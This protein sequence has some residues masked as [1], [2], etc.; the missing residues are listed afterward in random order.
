MRALI[1]GASSGLGRDMARALAAR[2][3]DLILVACREDRLKELASSLSV[4]TTVSVRDLSDADECLRLFE[5]WEDEPLEMLVNNAG[6]GLFGA[7]DEVDL[8]RELSMI[9]VNVRAVHILTKRFAEK[10]EKQGHGRILN[11]ASSAG[12]LPGPLMSTYY[13]T[14]SYVVRYSEALA[15]ELRRRKSPVTI[16]LLC[17]GPV[18]TEFDRVAGVQFSLKGLKSEDVAEYAVR[19]TL[20]GKRIITPGVVMRMVRF[21]QRLLPDFLLARIAYGQQHRKRD[22]K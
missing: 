5:E 15:E 14:K 4:N 9:D 12:F 7:Y 13:A 1:T 16:S 6:F 20:R 10:F 17:P 8:Q 3:W 18:R 19:K 11:V 21:G 22:R 2:G